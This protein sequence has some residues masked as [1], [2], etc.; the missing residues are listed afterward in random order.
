MN[1][2]NNPVIM[3][4]IIVDHYKNPVHSKWNENEKF[5]VIRAK[6]LTCIDDLTLQMS[7]SKD[8]VKTINFRGEACAIAT[9]ST[10]IVAELIIN[11]SRLDAINIIDNYLQMITNDKYDASLLN[12]ALV[13]ANVNKQQH[14]IKCA[15]LGPKAL[16]QLIENFNNVN[17]ESEI[18]I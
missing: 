18:K 4:Q 1:F 13:F 5:L 14:R 11:K 6:S 8:K 10:D 7:F 9:A 12:E 16:K 2:L 17:K 3:R 15:V